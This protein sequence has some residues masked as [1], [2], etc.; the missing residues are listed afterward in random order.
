MSSDVHVV[1]HPDLRW[2]YEGSP[3]VY[4]GRRSESVDP[5]PCYP[6]PRVV[7]NDALNQVLEILPARWPLTFWLT[8]HEGLDRMNGKSWYDTDYRKEPRTFEHFHTTLWVKRVQP[9]PAMTRYLVAHEY[10]HHVENWIAEARG[11]K[12]DSHEIFAIS[13]EYAQL[14]GLV[15]IPDHYGPGVWH[16]QPAE[17][18]ANDFRVGICVMETEFWPHPGIPRPSELPASTRRKLKAWWDENLALI[19]TPREETT[20][21]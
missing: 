4:L 3:R 17:V 5:T 7:V 2:Q 16:A 8:D 10:G 20:A 21:A 15:G 12:I 1:E 11:Y 13:K 9:H 19:T 18:F 14:R 6:H